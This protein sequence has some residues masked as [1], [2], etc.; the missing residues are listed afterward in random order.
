MTDA[1]VGPTVY[2][3]ISAFE[4]QLGKHL[5]FS[6]WHE[7]TQKQIDLFADG[8]RVN[9]IS[10]NS[11]RLTPRAPLGPAR[12]EA[13]STRRRSRV[14]L[15]VQQPLAD[16]LLFAQRGNLVRRHAEVV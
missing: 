10:T 8:T 13:M 14:P 16:D 4:A 2:E 1:P 15:R 6:D 12:G 5:G 7:V 3:G 11:G 9:G